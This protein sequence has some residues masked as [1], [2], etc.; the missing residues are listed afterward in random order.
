[1][2]VDVKTRTAPKD[3]LSRAVDAAFEAEQVPFFARLVERP[4]CSRE[5]EDVEKAA[6]L[7]DE[8]AQTL[9]LTTMRVAAAGGSFADHRVY[10]T[11][12]A[13]DGSGLLLVG[14][15]DTVF[16]RALGFFGFARDGDVVRG[17]GVLDMKS[18]LTCIFVALR[19]V[20][21]VAPDLCQRLAA[22]ILI[23]TDEEVGSPSSRSLI[24][25]EADRASHA[26]VFEAGRDEDRI[27]TR[28]K[29]TAFFRVVA[30][31]RAAHAGL[32][33]AEGRNAIH[34]LALA[35]P[36][37]A[38]ITDYARGITVNVGLVSGGT[39]K[40][41]VPDAAHADI[42]LRFER[43]E[44]GDALVAKL[45]EALDI[46]RSGPLEGTTLAL[47]GRIARPPMAPSEASTTLR[48]AYEEHAAAAGLGVGEAPLQGGGSDANLIAARGT[49]CIDGLGPFGK[50]F[51][52]VE[53][54]SSLDSLRRRTQALACFLADFRDDVR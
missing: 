25:A 36:R 15:V 44:D 24:E 35:I 18:G 8:L 37:L 39:S 10:A 23:N 53:E 45:T 9:G 2:V 32:A 34:A 50:R 48:L 17:P 12:A 1:M 30:K 29:G 52:S 43:P 11:E 21:E 51:H 4:S 28:R 40:N 47:E 7:L 54:W 19:A 33:H 38:A 22:R 42:D 3:A 31:G 16:P 13:T 26:L 6:A 49:P 41:T 46:D 5:P 27:V 14:H 20:G